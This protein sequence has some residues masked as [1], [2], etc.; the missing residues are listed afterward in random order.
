MPVKKGIPVIMDR[1][2]AATM[3]ATVTDLTT[4]IN[5]RT[6]EQNL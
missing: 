6:T 4:V 5:I 2:V 3:V 1:C